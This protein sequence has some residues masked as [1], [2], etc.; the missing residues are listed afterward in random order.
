VETP[1]RVDPW[2]IL[3][4]LGLLL[5]VEPFIAEVEAHVHP[6]EQG[7]EEQPGEV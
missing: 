7:A 2:P 5:R 6:P 4:W 1:Q 3:G